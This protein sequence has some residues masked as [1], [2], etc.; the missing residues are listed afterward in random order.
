MITETDEIPSRKLGVDEMDHAPGAKD[1]SRWAAPLD[2]PTEDPEEED[3][4]TAALCDFF[5]VC[6]SLDKAEHCKI[7]A[8][9]I[10]ILWNL[11]ARD[12][13]L[14]IKLVADG[15]HFQLQDIAINDLW[16]PAVRSK[17]IEYAISLASWGK[18]ALVMGGVDSLE[19][20]LVRLVGSNTPSLEKIASEG[21]ARFAFMSGST[22][23]GSTNNKKVI[24]QFGGIEALIKLVSKSFQRYLGNEVMPQEEYVEGFPVEDVEPL[25]I[26]YNACLALHNLSVEETNQVPIGKVGLYLFLEIQTYFG[27]LVTKGLFDNDPE[28]MDMTASILQNISI[29]PGNRTRIYKAELRGVVYKQIAG[30]GKKVRKGG[31]FGGSVESPKKEPLA[32][33]GTWT[34]EKAGKKKA[35]EEVKDAGAGREKQ[36]QMKT[37]FLEWMHQTFDA[38]TSPVPAK[39]TEEVDHYEEEDRQRIPHLQTVLRQPQ[40][41]MWHLPA[42]SLATVGKA[43]WEPK[44]SEY[45]QPTGN[46]RL[47]TVAARLL[48]TQRPKKALK[49][50]KKAR[51]LSMETRKIT[52]PE[53]ATIERPPTELRDADKVPLTRIL[54]DVASGR[55]TPE[56]GSTEKKILQDVS[57][58]ILL[59]PQR[60]RTKISFHEDTLSDNTAS[61]AKLSIWEHTV[62]SR[63]SDDL[64]PS[65]QLPN[66]LRAHYYYVRGKLI[67]EVE[68]H[69][70]EVPQR[71]DTL[72][73]ALQATLPH[74]DS[75]EAFIDPRGAW[76][77]NKTLNP[78]PKLAPLPGQHTL[79]VHHPDKL[80]IGEFGNL[81]E[82][83]PLFIV[84]LEEVSKHETI[85]VDVTVHKDEVVWTL[86]MS[87]FKPRQRESDSKGFF[88]SD[89]CERRAMNSDWKR[90]MEKEKFYNMLVRENKANKSK[91]EKVAIQELKK[92]FETHWNTLKSL[93][94][95]YSATGSG[96]I[97]HCYFNGWGSFVEQCAIP[98]PSSTFTKRSD[99]D[100]V[101]ITANFVQDKKTDSKDNQD[102]ALLLRFEWLE[103]IIRTAIAKYG[104]VWRRCGVG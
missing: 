37:E 5:M 26:L 8:N 52:L 91:R 97:Y 12:E 74:L 40:K 33:K 35:D 53:D 95:Y 92:S 65:Y 3:T 23:K 55:A 71:P 24:A 28:I 11:T 101:F 48:H 90:L 88:D 41:L 89:S 77:M 39:E 63:V 50:I 57:L 98:D 16:C 2:V 85:T 82:D 30:T 86:P 47:P 61:G 83:N 81:R 9:A 56:L 67:D 60:A 32:V 103:A 68:V 6:L 70:P 80:E 44:I 7:V 22:E 36:P 102:K 1:N 46:D 87:I 54:P 43:R 100:T 45:Q 19:G 75:L 14:E 25:D 62:G 29:H 84:R 20:I 93:F 79:L 4:A 96:S 17:A 72:P 73:G 49:D 69:P 58:D 66:G 31:T 15:L 104:R 10:G 18:T 42:R 99:C 78:V 34:H 94:Q 21:L 51:E 38:E 64:Y 27:D 76:Q 13:A 59:A